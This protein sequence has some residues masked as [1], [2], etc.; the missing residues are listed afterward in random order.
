[1]TEDD[2]TGDVM[3]PQTERV[4]D[5]YGD[6]IPV[7]A[8]PDGKPYVALLP[9]T[10]HLGLDP[11]SQRRRVQG[12][13]SIA[14]RLRPFALVSYA[15]RQPW[16]L[17]PGLGGH[18]P[19]TVAVTAMV[20]VGGEGATTIRVLRGMITRDEKGGRMDG[21]NETRLVAETAALVPRREQAVDFYGDA[22]PVAQTPDGGLYVALRP[23]TD[24]LGLDFSAQRRRVL[25]DEVIA[26]RARPVLIT[27]ADGRQREQLC[28]PLDLLPGWLFGV[29]TARVRPELVEKI[30]R[31]RADCFR[32]LWETFKGDG[33]AEDERHP[34]PVDTAPS[35]AALALEIATAVQHLAQ[36][37]LDI[38]RRLTDVAARHDV[39]ADY[40]RG[41]IRE[42][43]LRL[44]SLERAT[45]EGATITEAQAAE[46]A[47]AV[48]AIG[49]RLQAGGD[50]EGYAKVY[51]ELYRRY[52]ISTYKGLPA[53]DYDGAMTW[54]HGWYREVAPPGAP[55]T[56]GE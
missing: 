42:T 43:N 20:E 46:I 6:G 53:T 21:D 30:N 23:I 54:L 45:G 36:N 55:L 52:R 10:D 37:Q 2:G 14:P 39:M 3:M 4:V 12:D 13:A 11:R 34:V 44:A 29:T 56:E 17:W 31:Y 25:R 16:P 19:S 47:L 41:F 26:P 40:V 5:F 38:E 18:A 24:F 35:G 48:K 32:V 1:M 22:I 49:Q 50:R 7:A 9:I 8:T 27:A 33:G 15:D 51:S 28:I